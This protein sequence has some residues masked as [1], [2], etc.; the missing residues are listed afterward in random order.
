MLIYATPADLT[1]GDLPW[2]PS[3]PAN[4]GSL[5][6]SASLLVYSATVA[7]FYNVDDTGLPTDATVLQAFKDA[8]CVQVATWVGLGMDPLNVGLDAKAPTRQK[9][10]DGASIAYDTSVAT[11]QAA[12][13]IRQDAASTLCQQAQDIL[14]QV[15]V[16]GTR[17]WTYG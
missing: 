17:L 10:L 12:L 2:L 7:A 4:A 14:R 11:S 3:A 6:R 13:A 9:T 5:L 16:L 8:T 15:R 1:T